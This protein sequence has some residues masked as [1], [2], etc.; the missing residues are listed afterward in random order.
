[1]MFLPKNNIY[2]CLMLADYFHK[3]KYFVIIPP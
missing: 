3:N 2:T 1:M